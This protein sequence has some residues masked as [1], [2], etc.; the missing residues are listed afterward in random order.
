[1]ASV[2]STNRL[3][4]LYSGLDTDALVKALVSTQQRKTDQMFQGMT[5]DEWKRDLYTD[6]NNQLR[7][8]REEYGSAV[9]SSSMTAKGTYFENTVEMTSNNSVSVKAGAS[10]KAGAYSIRVDQLAQASAIKGTKATTTSQGLS[11]TTLDKTPLSQLVSL[12]SGAFSSEE[13]FSFTLNGKEFSFSGSTTIKNVMDTVNKSGVGVT[14]SYSQISDSFS[15]AAN[16]MG[17]YRGL[18]DPGDAPAAP[19]AFGGVRPVQE[20]YASQ[21]DF[22]QALTQYTSEKTDYETNVYKPYATQLEAWQNAKTEYTADQKRTVAM[23][24][25]DGFLSRLGMTSLTNGQDAKVRVNGVDH[26]VS[27]NSLQLDGIT[28]TLL[29]PSEAGKTIDFTV[30]QNQQVSVDKIKTFVTA[31]NELVSKLFKAANEKKNY[32]YAPLTDEQRADLSEGEAALWDA[33][34]KAGLL[35]RDSN[36]NKILTDLRAMVTD[37]LGSA[38]RLGDIGITVSKYAVGE[39]FTLE[40]DAEKLTKAISDD[41]ERLYNLFAASAQGTQKGGLMTRINESI[42]TFTTST[43]SNAI[44]AL[45]NNISAYTKSIKAQDTKIAQL[46]EKYYAQYAKLETVL[47]QLQS[48]ST[49]MTNMFGS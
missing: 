24:D 25:A 27:G 22:Q 42:S 21:D 4:G 5:R 31:F 1:M 19:A 3:T 7:I 46:S 48:Q 39:P 37:Q 16:A 44:Q 13:S 29:G 20:D 32:G 47:G 12:S 36:L 49:Q 28:F 17:E 38:G 30:K 34:S 15:I 45:N 26:T 43:K 33:K 11:A 41:P 23:E 6:F 35:Y 10:A 8:F 18:P 40:I 9:G 2:D 14:M